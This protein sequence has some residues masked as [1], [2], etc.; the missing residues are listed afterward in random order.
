MGLS[1]KK[2]ELSQG[3]AQGRPG[4]MSLSKKE[5]EDSSI[6]RGKPEMA[7]GNFNRWLQNPERYKTTGL[8]EK[9]IAE[10]KGKLFGSCG[11]VIQKGEIEEIKRQIELGKWG[12]FKGLSET[13][14]KDAV[15]LIGG[16]LGK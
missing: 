5:K 3:R 4:E 1:E 13:E 2:Q 12:K 7:A 9:K 14:K 10:L 11:T 15:K 16:I 8:G 6:F